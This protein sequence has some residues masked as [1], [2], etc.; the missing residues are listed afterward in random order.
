MY[1]TAIKYILFDLKI[2]KMVQKYQHLPMKDLP[3]FT[4][5]VIF[6]FANIPSGNTGVR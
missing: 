6:R 2:D 1:Q 3:K 4:Q 5:I